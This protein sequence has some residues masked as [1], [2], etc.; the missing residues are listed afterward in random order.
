MLKEVTEVDR[1][2]LRLIESTGNSDG[3]NLKMLS[4]AV[5]NAVDLGFAVRKREIKKSAAL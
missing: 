5:E 4:G 1:T 3:L 2:L